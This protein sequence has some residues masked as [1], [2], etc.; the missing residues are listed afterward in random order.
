MVDEIVVEI[1]YAE[2]SRAILREL[3]LPAH[4][5]VA[6]ALAASALVSELQLDMSQLTLGIWSKPVTMESVLVD[7]DRIELYRPLTIDPMDARRKRARK[8]RK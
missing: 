1:A 8:S 6:D 3:T 7:G 4:S 2:P 5:T